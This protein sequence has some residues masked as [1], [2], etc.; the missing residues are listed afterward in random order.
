MNEE[1]GIMRQ[2]Q[3][4]GEAGTEEPYTKPQKIET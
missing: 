3:G 1:G 4:D 2:V